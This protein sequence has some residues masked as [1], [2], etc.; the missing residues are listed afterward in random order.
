MSLNT[1]SVA[2]V[3]VTIA[4]L[5]CSP[6][7]SPSPI[8][9]APPASSPSPGPA[10]VPTDGPS[11]LATPAASPAA[12]GP[13]AADLDG[14]LTTPE[15]AHRLPLAI[16]ID[17]ARPGRPQSGFNAASIVW[18]APA[19]GFESRYL[20]VVQEGTASNIGPVR[21]ARF[22]LAHWAAE[23]DAAF[24]HYGGDLL[25]RNWMIANRGKLFTDVDGLGAGNPAYH[26]IQAR[27]AP[28]NAF[29]S[30]EDL[31]RVAGQ[32]GGDTA[33]S[34][35]VHLRPFREDLP[36]GSRGQKQAFTIPYH[37]VNVRYV[38]DPATN[39][40]QRF[41]NGAAQTDQ[42]D[43]QLVTA[44]TI[45]VLFMT[46]RTDSTIEAGHNRPV[47][48]FIGSGVAWVYTEGTLVKGRW[49]KPHEGDPTV[50]LGPDGVE[51]PFV[52]GR[53]FMQVVPI[54]TKVGS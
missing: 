48:G 32:L 53:I 54:G 14:V 2:T 23:L 25:T 47:L 42:M 20:F 6:A 41:V 1:R 19:D 8:A 30:S 40:Y 26:R 28:Y 29:T 12:T 36:A 5:G 50:I 4:L 52:R 11:A 43:G 44:R 34:P 18:Q 7:A 3:L 45:V 17:D 31:W 33:I 13:V 39:A 16:S 15:L 9:S 46:F 22:Y 24:A 51:L 49:S 38:Y 21:S 35:A 27:A 10:G 37:T